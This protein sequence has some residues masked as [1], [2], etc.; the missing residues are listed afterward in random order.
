MNGEVIQLESPKPI[1]GSLMVESEPSSATIYIDGK[2]M[3]ETPKLIK[4]ILV[5]QH[6]IKLTKKGCA[7]YTEIVTITKGERKQVTATL[8]TGKE[9]QFTCNVPDAQLE[10]DGQK[11]DSANG[12]YMLTYGQHS[13][14]ATAADYSEYNY[15]INVRESSR[16]HYIQMQALVKDIQNYQQPNT[17][18]KDETVSKRINTDKQVRI[19]KTNAPKTSNIASKLFWG[20]KEKH[21]NLGGFHFGSGIVLTQVDSESYGEFRGD[22]YYA[23]L[24]K[25]PFYLNFDLIVNLDE[26]YYLGVGAG[27]AMTLTDKL[28]I[29]YGVGYRWFIEDCSSFNV[30][31]GVTY[32]FDNRGWGG[33]SYAFEYPFNKESYYPMHKLTYIFGKSP[34]VIVVGGVTLLGL[35]A[36]M[37][38]AY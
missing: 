8:S 14:R 10:I 29:N 9:I 7:D 3:G 33:F 5:G 1:L 22:L 32:M 13:L 12:T 16:N 4:E 35:I 15:T 31:A 21:E 2:E 17:L 19:R 20:S 24:R 26:E 11:V 36:V 6:G 30:N 27:S 18:A 25:F 28:A 34:S 37:A 38:S 23:N